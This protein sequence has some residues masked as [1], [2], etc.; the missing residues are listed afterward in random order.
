MINPI[1]VNGIISRAQDISILRHNEENRSVIDQNNFQHK[2]D[3]EIEQNIR[4]VRQSDDTDKTDT[5]HD[6]KE[7]GK[8]S[9]FG[10]GGK[11]KKPDEQKQQDGKVFVKKTG[12][13]DIKI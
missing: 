5:R 2:F 11:K 6:A 8:N 10:D 7:K 9:Y 4:T 13:F 1:E 12:G 3:Q